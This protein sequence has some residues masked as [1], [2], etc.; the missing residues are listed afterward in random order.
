MRFS[1]TVEHC[2][3]DGVKRRTTGFLRS[4]KIAN[5]YHKV[6]KAIPAVEELIKQIEDAEAKLERYRNLKEIK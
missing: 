2:L 6:S 5:I 1:G 4:N 3:L